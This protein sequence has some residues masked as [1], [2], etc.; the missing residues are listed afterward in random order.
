[1][2]SN[3]LINQSTAQS[4][5]LKLINKPT[6]E[7]ELLKFQSIRICLASPDRIKE[8]AKGPLNSTKEKTNLKASQVLNPKTFNYKTLKPEKGGLFCEK[9]FGSIKNSKSRRYKLAYIQLVSPVTHI[10]YLKGS[11]SY[12]SVLLNIKKKKL[13]A[14]TYCSELLSTHIKSFKH[15]LNTKN[16]SSLIKNNNCWF[17]YEIQKSLLI[18]DKNVAIINQNSPLGLNA[19]WANFILVTNFKPLLPL[20]NYLPEQFFKQQR[21]PFLKNNE[22]GTVLLSKN[23]YYNDFP[24]FLFFKNKKLQTYFLNFLSLP[25]SLTHETLKNNSNTNFFVNN[26]NFLKQQ[27]F[28]FFSISFPCQSFTN[29][30]FSPALFNQI[31]MPKI[32]KKMHLFATLNITF[33]KKT[34]LKILNSCFSYKGSWQEKLIAAVPNYKSSKILLRF[35]KK[36]PK[37]EH[38]IINYINLNKKQNNL[39]STNDHFLLL[40]MLLEQ[41]QQFKFQNKNQL[42]TKNFVFNNMQQEFKNSL[43][44]LPFNK[45]NQQKLTPNKKSYWNYFANL[46]LD[47]IIKKNNLEKTNLI[48][49]SNFATTLKNKSKKEKQQNKQNFVKQTNV[50][51]EQL[52]QFSGYCFSLLTYQTKFK[53]LHAGLD[54]CNLFDNNLSTKGNN[55]T[56]Q[57][58]SFY[59]KNDQAKMASLGTPINNDLHFI[60]DKNQTRLVEQKVIIIST[61]KNILQDQIICIAD[62][63]FKNNCTELLIEQLE[64]VSNSLKIKQFTK[65][66]LQFNHLPIDLKINQRIFNKKTFSK[67]IS[68]QKIL[69]N[70]LGNKKFR[71]FLIDK[72][73]FSIKK[74]ILICRLKKAKKNLHSLFLDKK[75]KENDL[76]FSKEL[77][78]T[79]SID[80]IKNSPNQTLILKQK[81]LKQE[82]RQIINFILKNYKLKTY[83]TNFVTL[84]NNNQNLDFFK[85]KIN[86]TF[87]S[88]NGLSNTLIQI[89]FKEKNLKFLQIYNTFSIT[90]F[91]LKKNLNNSEFFELIPKFSYV[92]QTVEFNN[93]F[94]N[95]QVVKN[96]N[97]PKNKGAFEKEGDFPKKIINDQSITKKKNHYYSIINSKP[98]IENEFNYFSSTEINKPTFSNSL[99]FNQDLLKDKINSNMA[100]FEKQSS[101]WQ[102]NLEIY[103]QKPEN[104][105]TIQ[106]FINLLQYFLINQKPAFVNKY[107]TVA[108]CF[109][110]TTQS[111]WGDFISYMTATAYEQ[112]KVIPS[113]V[114]RSIC[115]DLPLTGAIAVKNLL[116]NFNGPLKRNQ[117]IKS[118]NSTVNSFKINSS[119]NRS[120]IE[121]LIDQIKGKI[122]VLNQQIQHYED[123]L[124]VRAFFIKQKNLSYESLNIKT[125][126]QILINKAFRKLHILRS[127]RANA[128]RR[129][130][131][132]RPFQKQNTCPEWMVLEVLPV[133]PPDLRPILVLDS[134]Q[135]AVSDLNKLYQK[136]IFRNE[137]LKRLYAD[138]YSLNFSPEMRYAQRLLQEAVDALIENGKGD[139]TPITASNNRPLKS[140]SDMVKGKKGR[141]RQN[142]LGKRVD[143]SGRSVIVVGPQLKLYECGLPKEM[144]IEL[145]QPFL[146]RRLITKKITRNFISAKKLIKEKPKI[147]WSILREVMENRPILL[148]RA[149]T[150]HRLGIQ[151]FK[152][153]LVSGRAILLHPLV[154]TSFNADFDGDQMAVHVPLSYQACSEAWKLM[155]GRNNIL[156]PATGE[157]IITPSQDMVLGCYYLTTLDRIKRKNSLNQFKLVFSDN[158]KNLNFF[159]SAL[160]EDL[161]AFKQNKLTPQQSLA[162]N[163]KKTI[164]SNIDQ[165]IQL[166]SQQCLDFHTPIWL[167]WNSNFEL[168]L[169]KQ[170]CLEMQIDSVGNIKKIYC[171][172]QTYYNHEFKNQSFY[173]K[174]TPG[175]VLI[176]K[177]ILETFNFNNISKR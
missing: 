11:T 99:L 164:F 171:E 142:L 154:C 72:M 114:E 47:S 174:T 89:G 146:I 169:K 134:Q 121:L 49:L 15:N 9:I 22:N 33:Y 162:T 144:A 27:P 118:V 101:Y 32:Q 65:R 1:M 138:F 31:E 95:S 165:V 157:P 79:Q 25:N 36:Y 16:I 61:F 19:S 42:T 7:S 48:N 28:V 87:F 2:D 14:I 128:F 62:L 39:D 52:T 64:Q 96:F 21:L 109:L 40:L 45:Q 78:K 135:V 117:T 177:L 68:K 158:N 106:N 136:V 163:L 3:L 63:Q 57:N 82:Q 137:R 55:Q 34:G 110:W 103:G 145:F 18:Q 102:K 130:K 76:L 43:N 170:T 77:F 141:F 60:E 91:Y 104:V 83:N 70:P 172:Y 29:F 71:D 173:I 147:I 150:L 119:S 98:L 100:Q 59:Y 132:L 35:Y 13:E 69:K 123:F 113:Y 44:I 4:E 93:D 131:I 85:N 10:W 97:F 122:I 90:Y 139:S 153:K 80:K 94:S 175:R 86:S 8:W 73:I 37:F 149:P 155:W 166:F 81:N 6:T 111:D 58:Q 51:W 88:Y 129:L 56:L 133:L 140:L 41:E 112:D 167:K 30:L 50:N 75:V 115:F 23:I 24:I 84:F 46:S 143:Y 107:Y 74:N 108:Q 161:F 152:P 124:K 105:L 66:A 156:S 176:N 5:F 120:N 26:N 92:K 20:N 159:S 53:F 38:F 160:S 127:L 168:N 148:N 126:P 17:D 116:R 125:G 54:N 67:K 12:I 151:A